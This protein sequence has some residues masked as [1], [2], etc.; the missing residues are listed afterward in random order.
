MRMSYFFGKG[1]IWDNQNTGQKMC[2]SSTKMEA[3]SRAHNP[4]GKWKRECV[5][6]YMM[7]IKWN[8]LPFSLRVASSSNPA[9]SS[10]SLSHSNTRCLRFSLLLPWPVV[11]PMPVVPPATV[12]TNCC[13]YWSRECSLCCCAIPAAHKYTL[14]RLL[15][16]FHEFVHYLAARNQHKCTV[17]YLLPGSENALFSS[18]KKPRNSFKVPPEDIRYTWFEPFFWNDRTV[19][20]QTFASW[21][22]LLQELHDTGSDII[23]FVFI[24]CS[25]HQVSLFFF[26][27]FWAQYS[28][29]F[30][31]TFIHTTQE[32]DV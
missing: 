17:R 21:T 25:L 24:R 18:P 11:P 29:G 4:D 31:H 14:T 5:W 1:K 32:K 19:E 27:L 12:A 30:I 2:R 13:W 23:I 3:P 8:R 9:K 7:G 15:L 26:P 16:D 22:T 6:R 10:S 28:Y 20:I